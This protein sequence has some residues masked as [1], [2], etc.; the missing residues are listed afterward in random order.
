MTVGKKPQGIAINPVTNTVYVTNQNS[1]YYL[2]I[3]GTTNT[4][5]KGDIQVGRIPFDVDCKSSH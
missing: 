4:V 5:L 3:N 1:N 2:V